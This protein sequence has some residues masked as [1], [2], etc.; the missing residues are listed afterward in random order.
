MLK[1]SGWKK[2]QE[3]AHSWLKNH[4]LGFVGRGKVHTQA[5]WSGMEARSRGSDGKLSAPNT[6]VVDADGTY[7]DREGIIRKAILNRLRFGRSG[8]IFEN[9]RTNLCVRAEEM[10]NGSWTKTRSSVSANDRAAPDGKTTADKLIE[11][12]SNNSHFASA[13]SISFT[14]GTQYVYSFYVRAAERSEVWLNFPAAPFPASANAFFDLS[15]SGS[16]GTVG[17]GADSA[18]IEALPDGWFRCWVIATADATTTGQMQVAVAIATEDLSY[19]GD[20]SSGAHF[21]G[22]Q[23]EVG[24]FPAT[25][26]PTTSVSVTR[27]AENIQ[28]TTPPAIVDAG[29][30]WTAL[31]ALTPTSDGTGGEQYMFGSSHD[32]SNY[33]WLAKQ[34]ATGK[35]WYRVRSGGVRQAYSI[36]TFSP[37]V[38]LV[39]A[40][41][42]QSV[43]GQNKMYINGVQEATLADLIES[44]CWGT[45]TNIGQN[46]SAVLQFFGPLARFTIVTP[47]LSVRQIENA[48]AVIRRAG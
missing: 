15:G 2:G 26:I 47:D 30:S 5:L 19:L 43:A 11:D 40:V 48:T 17:A 46:N 37:G 7:E 16:V 36:T 38:M 10:D 41:L 13:S 34:A 42:M 18:G 25:Y 45:I 23:V 6:E 35:L 44:D 32:G 33:F 9:A 14:S 20:G 1:G 3:C 4:P 29:G 8:G 22:A 31:I 27:A 24:D 28:L 39:A 12:T 21:W